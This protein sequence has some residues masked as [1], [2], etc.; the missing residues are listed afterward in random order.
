MINPTS[1]LPYNIT[2]GCPDGYGI[3]SPTGKCAQVAGNGYRTGD[4]ACDDNN[5]VDGDG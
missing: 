4:E 5:T 2:V 1:S 3:S